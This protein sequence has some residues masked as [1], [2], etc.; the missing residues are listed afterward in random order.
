[1]P[2]VVV[3]QQ[4]ILEVVKVLVAQELVEME[5]ILELKQH[6]EQ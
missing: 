2:L 4:A 5:L 6:L 1:L 3:E